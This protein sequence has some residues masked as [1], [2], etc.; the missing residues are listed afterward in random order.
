MGQFIDG[1][2]FSGGSH[3]MMPKTYIRD[4]IDMAHKHN[5]YVSSGDCAETC[6]AKVLHILKNTSSNRAFGAYVVPTPRSSGTDK[7]SIKPPSR[8]SSSIFSRVSL[9]SFLRLHAG[10]RNRSDF[11]DQ[12]IVLRD[13]YLF[14]APLR[15]SLEFAMSIFEEPKRCFRRSIQG[16]VFSSV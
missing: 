10:D 13:E 2:K 1:L 15:S 16:S 4:V 6:F 11:S 14:I 9:L 5:V 8:L 7:S 3:S 12:L